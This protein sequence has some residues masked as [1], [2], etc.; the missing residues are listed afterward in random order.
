MSAAP[1]PIFRRSHLEEQAKLA[2]AIYAH[3]TGSTAAFEQLGEAHRAAWRELVEFFEQN[4]ECNRCGD[5]LFCLDCD[6]A[7]IK[8]Y[9]SS[10]AAEKTGCVVKGRT[11]GEDFVAA[12]GAAINAARIQHNLSIR[13]AA[14]GIGISE[15]ALRRI[16]NGTSRNCR[17]QTLMMI[18]LWAHTKLGYTEF[19]GFNVRSGTKAGIAK[20]D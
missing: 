11:D 3:R 4:P 17:G 6:R 2:Y 10:E 14:K 19:A 1:N 5:P 7:E 9:R 15:A 20:A 16:E 8:E 12:L 13:R 18:L